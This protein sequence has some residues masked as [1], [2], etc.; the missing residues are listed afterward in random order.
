MLQ[1]THPLN[2]FP[3]PLFFP[4]VCVS[5]KDVKDKKIGVL[6]LSF[7]PNTDDMRFAPSIY[8][9]QELQKEGGK[10]KAYDPEAMEKAKSILNNVEFCKD[11]YEAAKDSDVLLLVTEWNEFKEMDLKKIKS[12]MRN[13]LI[14]DG[15]NI[16]N[17]EELKKEGFSYISMGRNEM[18]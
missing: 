6:G 18:V 7:K 13:P 4:Q 8:I 1:D 15:R 16:Y 2:P 12:L 11:P 10:I 9:I 14:I 3:P 17:P 5:L